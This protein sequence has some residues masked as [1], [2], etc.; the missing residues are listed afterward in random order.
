MSLENIDMDNGKALEYEFLY[1]V[2]DQALLFLR[3]ARTN[4]GYVQEILQTVDA[5]VESL[6]RE[7]CRED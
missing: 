6:G 5:M 3:T 7:V 2:R 4:E 1:N